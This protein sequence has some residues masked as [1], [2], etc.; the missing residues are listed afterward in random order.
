MLCPDSFKGSLSAEQAAQAMAEG[1]LA[2]EPEAE[3]VR[4][5]I[6]DGGEGTMQVLQ[7]AGGGQEVRRQ[8]TGPYGELVAAPY[9]RIGKRAIAEL[10]QASGLLV[11]G[12]REPILSTT[13]G[14]GMLLRDALLHGAEEVC[15]T[16]GGS[17]TNDGGAGIA[18]ALGIRLLDAAGREL[19]PNCEGLEKLARVDAS[20]MLPQART[21]RFLIACDV[22]NPRVAGGRLGSLRP[23][24]GG[25]RAHDRADGCCFRALCAPSG[26]ADGAGAPLTAWRRRGG[27]SSHPPAGVCAGDAVR[28]DRPGAGCT[29]L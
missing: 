13:Y 26:A 14:T 20:G 7:R 27:W 28:G 8:V 22:R 9:L 2:A 29:G 24:K 19:P 12:R 21:C 11:T 25:R 16:L 6:A 23:A 10:A 1:I 4:F 3:I 18:A 17:A 5:P 15:L